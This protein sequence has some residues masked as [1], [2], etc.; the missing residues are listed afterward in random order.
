MIVLRIRIRDVKMTE[1]KKKNYESP[2]E[3]TDWERKY[4]INYNSDVFEVI[5]HLQLLLMETSPC[6]A[7]AMVA[8]V[9]LS[10][11]TTLVLVLYH[12]IG[13]VVGFN[14]GN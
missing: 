13:I 3:W 14:V 11:P 4:F 10:V 2:F 5:G 8:L 7:L 9:A 12:F 1:N 6:L